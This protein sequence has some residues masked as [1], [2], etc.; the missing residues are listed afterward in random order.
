MIDKSLLNDIII[1]RVEPSIYAFSTNTIPNYLKVGDTYRPV[2]IRLNEWKKHFP[3]LK[4]E[5]EQVAKVVENVYFRDFSVH[6]FLE[7]DKKRQ[8]LELSN[9][10]KGIY[11]SKEFFKNA[12][13]QDVLDAINVI[14]KDYN[15]KTNKYNFYNAETLRA[16]SFTYPRIETYEPRK[17]TQDKTIEKFK[18]AVNNGRTNLLMYAVMRFGKSFT[19]M[20]C[21]VEN[22]SKLVVIVSAKADVLLEWKKTVQS[23]VKFVDYEFYTSMDLI[24]NP[25]VITERLA[26]NKKAVAFFTLQDLQGN[27]IKEKHQEI[28]GQDIDLLIIDETHF[29]ARAEKFGKVLRDSSDIKASSHK[30]DEFVD[31]KE[32]QEQIDKAF[33][34]KIKLHLSG[35][36]YRILMGSEFE[37]EDIIAFYQFTD[38]VKEQE[39]WDKKHLLKDDCKEWDNPYYGFPQMIRFAFNPSESAR[40]KMEEMKN[41]GISYAF[42]A[43]LKPKAIKKV[44]DNSHKEFKHKQEILELLEVI[45]GSKEDNEVLG[46]LNYENIKNG[47][48]CR[49]IVMVLPYCASCDAMEKLIKDNAEKFKNL[50]EYEIINI[51]G[52]DANLYKSTQAVKSKISDCENANKKTITLTVNRMLTGTTVQEWDTMIYLKDTASP[53]EYDQSIF[54]LQNQ[55][56]KTYKNKDNDSIKYN[57]KPQ[58]LL[59]DF[60]PN[61]VFTM[62]EQ[63]AQI[64][65]VNVD[66]AG[67]SKLSDRIEEELKIS[68]IIFVNKDK[69]DKVTPSDIIKAVSEYSKTRGV[70]EETIEIPVDLS[71]LEIEG[72]RKVIEQ[73]NELGSKAGLSVKATSGEGQDLD[74]PEDESSPQENIDT[75]Q[76]NDTDRDEEAN[77]DGNDNT[78]NLEKQFRTYYARIL[79][80]SFL[81]DDTVISLQEIINTSDKPNNTRILK[82]LGLN[83]LVLSLM[84]ENM[85]KWALRKLDYKIHNINKLSHDTTV[86]AIERCNVAINKFGKL[87]ESEVL[88][89]KNICKDII[90]LITDEQLKEIIDKGEKV[91]DIASK[92]GEFAVAIYQR[93]IKLGYSQDVIANSIY[94]I[95]TSTITY[96]FTRKIY[97]V[98][99]LN[100][101]NIAEHF[102]SYDLL[103]FKDEDTQ[104]IDYEKLSKL[105][106]QCKKFNEINLNEEI[107]E[108]GEKVKFSAIVGNPPYQENVSN[109]EENSSLGKQLFPYFIKLSTQLCEGFCSLITPT[110]WFT[111]DA[112]DKSFLKLR[113]YFRVNNHISHIVIYPTT[114]DVFDSVVIKGGISYFL[115]N[116]NHN[117]NVAFQTI[118]NNERSETEN[119]PL[120]EA[121]Y[122]IVFKSILDSIITKKVIDKHKDFKS[123]ETIS[124]GRNAFGI[125]GKPSVLNKL[126][127][128]VEFDNSIKVYCK[129]S[130][131]RW[132]DYSN[133]TKNKNLI[134]KYKVFI[135]KSA[136]D[137]DNDLKVIGKAFIGEINSVCT[138]TYFPV[139][140]FISKNEADNLCKYFATKFL[141]FLVNALKSSQNVTQIV[142]R[143]VPLQNFTANSDI[144]WSKA[145]SEI[146]QQLYKKYELTKEEIDFIESMIKPME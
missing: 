126:T 103:K 9:T 122:S 5:F 78:K 23:H 70:A 20:C 67:N 32:A 11:Y 132:I 108:G 24:S 3:E 34:A 25:K 124:T 77:T 53:Q 88:T 61:R 65:N 57:M 111:G 102:T 94:S 118:K 86:S 123:I 97:E 36:P 31:V 107:I 75:P 6:E 48:M 101:E 10:P 49:H 4:K 19:S 21:A 81:T 91:L 40:K 109:G 52:V 140:E 95:P 83:K 45:D 128:S 13:K 15:D 29:G 71:L 129:D 115:F 114:K 104:D 82:N 92:A 16:Q 51:S 80:Y 138:D 120:F 37:E 96:A 66:E 41:N 112:Q 60:D 73:E 117:G 27:N 127:K 110:R 12:T 55:Y 136:G 139:G 58:T 44:S 35:T 100:I 47:K 119:R 74:I 84:A 42:S 56:V 105:L 64:Y 137:P 125:I 8:R 145:I 141:R 7:N 22:N 69:L 26:Q 134:N 90:N 146:D 17:G 46:F 54:R 116:K 99:G 2:A 39:E 130:K 59:V 113:E 72:I 98:L 63:K 43:L 89:P 93:L 33:K 87:G 144:D 143:F 50:N 106:T 121:N 1:G 30:Y 135:S 79:F 142:Y 133:V 62:Q 68:P 18:K 38:I 76:E 14:K 131:I 85:D 28:F